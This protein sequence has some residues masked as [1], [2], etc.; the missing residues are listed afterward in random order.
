MRNLKQLYK[1]I[2]DN[3]KKT[4]T[5]RG[6]ITWDWYDIMEDIFKEDRTINVGATL[7]SMINSDEMNNIE[8]GSTSI[9]STST[10]NS[11]H[12]INSDTR[13]EITENLSENI[14]SV[15]CVKEFIRGNA[16]ISNWL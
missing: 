15:R 12:T 9:P 10:G 8:E 11:E 14:T 16:Y 3:N 1:S 2:K 4:S 6:R 7:S 5:G 13:S